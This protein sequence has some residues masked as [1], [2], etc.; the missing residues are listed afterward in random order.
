MV[1]KKAAADNQ[2]DDEAEILAL[3]HASQ[4]ATWM[5]DFAAFEKCFIHAPYTARWNASHAT[6]IFVRRG[7]E[8]IAA[9]TRQLMSD[10]SIQNRAYAYETTVEDLQIRI[11]GDLAWATFNQ[12]YP[13]VP[14]KQYPMGPSPTHE[15]RV[16]GK[17]DGEW[18][19]AFL[20]S[21]SANFS[22]LGSAILRLA[23]DGAVQWR[24]PEADAVL[25]ADDD[26]VVRGGKL[27]IR[28]G[29]ADQ[30]LQAAIRWAASLDATIIPGRGA[31]PIVLD[32]GEGLPAKVWW[33]VAEAG[34][35]L[36][37]LANKSFDEQRLK[38]ASAVYELSP[39]Q[40]QVATL[41][42]EGLSLAD[43]ATRMK[44][45]PNTA[46]THL[47]RVFEKTGVRTQSA[48]V[49]VLLSTAAP[50]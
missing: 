32:G 22:H 40:K 35:I 21:L 18:R 6:G 17:Q 9:R 34:A 47:D 16:F 20:C 29:R 36:F 42:V 10:P 31:L 11:S 5:R 46:R 44:I 7:W 49:R 37:S 27:R 3:I 4:I 8:E 24:S 45:T 43:I 1:R 12:R 50:F 25:A 14:D 39:A 23:P 13:N 30:K 26:L 19:I 48:L 38:A 41:I 28:D 33:I 2:S 15:A